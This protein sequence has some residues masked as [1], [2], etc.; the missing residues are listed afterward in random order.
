MNDN[1]K[2]GHEKVKLAFDLD[3]RNNWYHLYDLREQLQTVVPFLGSGT[4]KAYGFPLW[5]DFIKGVIGV[6]ENGQINSDAEN[7]TLSTIE[8]AKQHLSDKN[9]WMLL[10]LWNQHWVG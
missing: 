3:F 2:K 8:E 4:S 7:D 1:K 10:M 6:I 5:P 9:S